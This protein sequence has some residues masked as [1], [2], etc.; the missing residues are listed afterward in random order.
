M[1]RVLF[2]S[3]LTLTA[4]SVLGGTFAHVTAPSTAGVVS[5]TDAKQSGSRIPAGFAALSPDRYASDVPVAAALPQ[6]ETVTV[7]EHAGLNDAAT[8]LPIE[9]RERS[10]DIARD[11]SSSQPL[12]LSTWT[13]I[14]VAAAH[15]L[16]FA[17]NGRSDQLD[18]S[19]VAGV[20]GEPERESSSRSRLPRFIAALA[21][22]PKAIFSRKAI[23]PPVAAPEASVEE[24]S[25]SDAH[26]AILTVDE[27]G[28]RRA[29]NAV[30]E[31]S[32]NSMAAPLISTFAV[33]PS[34][35]LSRPRVVELP[36]APVFARAEFQSGDHQAFNNVYDASTNR[37]RSGNAEARSPSSLPFFV[38]AASAAPESIFNRR[39]IVELPKAPAVEVFAINDHDSEGDDKDVT[40]AVRDVDAAAD[41]SA[42]SVV[43][44]FVTALAELPGAIVEMV[45]PTEIPAAPAITN[46]AVAVKLDRPETPAARTEPVAITANTAMA[47]SMLT[48]MNREVLVDA[49]LSDE[50]TLTA[51]NMGMNPGGDSSAQFDRM[52]APS[53]AAKSNGPAAVLISGRPEFSMDLLKPMNAAT[54]SPFVKLSGQEELAAMQRADNFCDPNWVGPPIR[55]SQTVQLK[56]EDLINQLHQRFGVN[57]IL[58][59]GVADLPMNVKAG[60]I[61][62]NVLLRSQLFVSG[63]RARCIDSNTVELIENQ[64]LPRLQDM[65]DVETRFV[66]LKFLQR[67][68][69]G[70]VDL[71]NRSQ[72]GQNG[73]QGGGC[74]GNNQGGTSGS[75]Q[76]GG[77]SG[78]GQQGQTAG[79]LAS[80]KFDKLIVE[81]E[82]ILGLRSMTES[83]AGGS[84]DSGGA[85]SQQT[86]VI[87]TNRFVT[88]IPGR[89]ILAI[90]AT[91]EEHELIDQIIVRA[92]RPPFQVSIKGLVYTA[93][94]DR[95]RDIG[96]QTTITGGTADNRVNGGIFGDTLGTGTLFDFSAVIGTF[97]FNVQAT[98]FQQN[99]I[100][101]VKSRPFATVIDGLCTTLDVGRQLPI[102]I[103]STLGGQGDVVFVNA[104]NNLAVTPYVI[105]DENGN[106][107]AVTLELRLTAND[108]DSSVT[109]RGVPAISARSIQTQLLLN[110]D[111]TAILGGFT[112]DSDSRTDRKVPGLGD[113]PIIGELFRRRIRDARMNRLYF[114]ISVDVITYPEA[115]R[116]VDVPGA[117]TDPP[118]ITPEQKKQGDRMEPKQVVAVPTP[119]GP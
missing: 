4:F 23:E 74:G 43:S 87:R 83:S 50:S 54:V 71:A 93:N 8:G 88:Q 33:T 101:S 46:N 52:L 84:G 60:S 119:K 72:G 44:S 2:I 21:E 58:G 9:V 109:A 79:Q 70:T 18:G 51:S 102:V 38:S 39:R 45:R 65:A 59:K 22:V 77:G 107:I 41:A 112:V 103:D 105:D 32:N 24:V 19:K 92:D 116:P 96:V 62:W 35:D 3:F 31:L 118:S 104:A 17:D 106:P 99:G 55:F 110:E 7:D 78:G 25:N 82:K 95:I 61:P 12:F 73:N 80:N 6:T 97:D 13:E 1:R 98:A 89:N 28:V 85:Q 20:Q 29:T 94:Q 53:S 37:D 66:K 75:V 63:V 11:A 16:G 67:T 34:G 64:E 42:S 90:R 100:I 48:P 57:F 113:I 40:G 36:A 114:A 15:S 30:P 56:L 14:P 47:T 117:T 81:I 26:L 91:K 76:G 115:I 69:S 86:E 10:N 49:P 27:A 5:L 108:I 111:K 68:G